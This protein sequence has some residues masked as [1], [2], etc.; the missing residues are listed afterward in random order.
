MNKVWIEVDNTTDAENEERASLL[1]K[2][3][4]TLHHND[5]DRKLQTTF[6]WSAHHGKYI[7]NLGPSGSFKVVGTPVSGEL[8]KALG[9]F[10]K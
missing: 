3:I 5:E 2:M 10:F 4:S 8:A 1:N 7:L 6:E 9:S